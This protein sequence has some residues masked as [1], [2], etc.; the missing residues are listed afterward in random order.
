MLLYDGGATKCLQMSRVG[1]HLIWEILGMIVQARKYGNK[2]FKSLTGMETDRK[3]V[4]GI[5]LPLIFP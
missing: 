4:D 1:I 3:R 5:I 2:W